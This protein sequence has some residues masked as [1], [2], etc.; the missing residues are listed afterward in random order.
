MDV[1]MGAST[2]KGFESSTY[3]SSALQQKAAQPSGRHNV[4]NTA[5]DILLTVNSFLC[6]N[7]MWENEKQL[8]DWLLKGG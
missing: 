8:K 3:S 4:R 7:T 6:G 1:I 5:A 2:Q